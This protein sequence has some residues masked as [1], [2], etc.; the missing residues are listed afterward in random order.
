[1]LQ[2]NRLTERPIVQHR[3]KRAVLFAVVVLVAACAPGPEDLLKEARDLQAAGRI[4]E[5]IPVLESLL[6][7]T[8]DDREANH[9][10][11]V[12]LLAT[13]Q[14]ALAIWPLGKAAEAP[15]A[16]LE[17]ALLLGRAHLTGG[18]SMDALVVVDRLIEEAPDLLEARQLRI[19]AYMESN[20]F[21]EALADAEYILDFRPDDQQT[22]VTRISILFELERAEE[23]EEAIATAKQAFTTAARPGAAPNAWE[24]RLCAVDATFQFEK[25]DEGH[26]DRARAAW[27]ACLEK[28]PAVGI[29][30][31]NA[32]AFFDALGE[33]ERSLEIIRSAV[34]RSPE[35]LDLRIGLGQRLG[36]MGKA[37]EAEKTL[38]EAAEASDQPGPWIT[39]AEFHDQRMQLAEARAATEKALERMHPPSVVLQMQ[40]ADLLIRAGDYEAA[41]KASETIEKPEYRSLLEGR[42]ALERG[43]PDRALELL[44]EGLRLWP[45]NSIARELAGQAAEQ[46]QD[47]DRAIEE[48]TESVRSDIDNWEA[49]ERLAELREALR[50]PGPIIQLANRFVRAHP[51]DPRGQILLARVSHWNGQEGLVQSALRDLRRM[52]GQ[53]EAAIALDAEFRAAKSPLN[54]V[55]F[56]EKTAIDVTRPASVGVLRLLVENLS[57]LG[58]HKEAISRA[59]A[60]IHEHPDFAAF[61]ELHANALDASGAPEAGVRAALERALELAPGRPSVLIA[62]GRLAAKHGRIDASIAF[63]DRAATEARNAEKSQKN[64]PAPANKGARMEAAWATIETLRADGRE[65]EA[66]RR[67]EAMSAEHGTHV[68]AANLMARRILESDGD[69]ARAAE[70][71][72]RAVRFGGGAEALVT[73]GRIQTAQGKTQPAITTLRNALKARP[74]LTTT[75]YW[76]GVALARAGETE[77]ARRELNAALASE[78]SIYEK[79]ARAE[80]ARLGPAAKSDS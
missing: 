74:D 28:F 57:K 15:D 59:R 12:A 13:G 39:L 42:I 35:N 31:S 14:P 8:P 16:A 33:T 69:L 64:P 62:L 65:V 2:S 79:D 43:Q 61:H 66:D 48:Y 80:L 3:I 58:R 63:F 68:G 78:G 1:M 71:S 34:E 26:V 41:E 38:R 27:E 77:E 18:S 7:E 55:T 22:L 54:A 50:S 4:A 5:S 6:N 30:V 29:V 21:E 11:G 52:P 37:E 67:L 44:A 10:L 51:E 70:L 45:S 73:L 23:A 47:Y 17:D 19:D 53:M 20:K 75:H 9:L 25:Q 36:A 32:M 60:A 49:L 76:L 56:I 40:Y 24:A 72:L 46:L